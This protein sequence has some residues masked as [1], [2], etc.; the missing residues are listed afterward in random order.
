MY[1]VIHSVEIHPT[2]QNTVNYYVLLVSVREDHQC[3]S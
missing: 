1:L 2:W 3:S